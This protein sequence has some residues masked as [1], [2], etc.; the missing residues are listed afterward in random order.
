MH[1]T[2]NQ[3]SVQQF[4]LVPI[5]RQSFQFIVRPNPAFLIRHG[6]RHGRNLQ[7][8]RLRVNIP[9][10]VVLVGLNAGQK[11]ASERAHVGSVLGL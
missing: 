11:D 9:M 4:I 1:G 5:V 10:L 6:Y 7:A 8:P 2:H 3:L